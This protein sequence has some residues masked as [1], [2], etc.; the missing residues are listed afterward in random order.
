MAS[1]LPQVLLLGHSFVKRLERDSRSNFDNR[2]DINFNLNGP[3]SVFLHDVGSRT[4]ANLRDFDLPVV[5]RAAPD[6]VILEIGITDLV[7]RSPE[8]VGSDIEDLVRLL[9]GCSVRVV[10]VCHVIPLGVSFFE[11]SFPLS[12]SIIM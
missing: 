11:A 3:A 1:P 2:A 8:V 9:V 12:F 6:I 4:V 5:K 10:G 7:G